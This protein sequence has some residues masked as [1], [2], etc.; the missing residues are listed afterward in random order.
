[1]DWLRGG[2]HG[3][4]AHR[5]RGHHR[6]PRRGDKGRGAVHD[7]GRSAGTSDK[8]TL[9]RRNNQQTGKPAMVG[10]VK[11]KDTA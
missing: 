11:G 10:L 3:G 4:R 2:N 1:M 5:Q 6:G 9:R 7:S 8:K